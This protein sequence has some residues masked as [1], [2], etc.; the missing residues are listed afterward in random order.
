MQIIVLLICS[1]YQSYFSVYGFTAEDAFLSLGQQLQKQRQYDAW[2]AV[3]VFL[4]DQPDPADSDPD[5]ESKLQINSREYAAH[6]QDVRLCLH[7]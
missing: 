1:N 4:K 6:M 7:L 2:N 5:L 3:S